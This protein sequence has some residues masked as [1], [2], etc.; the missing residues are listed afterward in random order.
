[1][2]RIIIA[3]AVVVVLAAGAGIAVVMNTD[4]G[5]AVLTASGADHTVSRAVV[6]KQ[7]KDH[8]YRDEKPDSVSCAGG[9]QAK[10]GESVQCTAVYKGKSR[11]MTIS[12][13]GVDGDEVTVDFAVL[14]NSE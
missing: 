1:M 12:V 9:L 14:E 10:N 11:P 2:K 3:L 5:G 4:N 8:P 6:E 13:S 7:A